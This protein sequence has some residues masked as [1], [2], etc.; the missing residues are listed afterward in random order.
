MDDTPKRLWDVR[1]K[2]TPNIRCC[3]VGFQ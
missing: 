1:Q 3:W 2:K